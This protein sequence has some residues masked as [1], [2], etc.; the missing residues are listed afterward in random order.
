M[1]MTKEKRSLSERIFRVLDASNQGFFPA[2]AKVKEGIISV[3]YEIPRMGVNKFFTL[4]VLHKE[5]YFDDSPRA[6]RLERECISLAKDLQKRGYKVKGLLG[7]IES[8]VFKKNEIS[9]Y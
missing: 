1:D 6:Y 4:D 8:P 7:F 3:Y 5:L 2:H 9:L